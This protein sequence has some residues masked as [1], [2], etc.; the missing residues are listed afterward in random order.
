MKKT[1]TLGIAAL[2]LVGCQATQRQNAT[3][4]EME[5]NSTTKG[6]IIGATSGAV[7]GMITGDSS[8]ERRKRALI[9]AAAGG[10]VGAGVGNYFDKQEAALR[11]ELVNSGVQVK[12]VG[13]DQ[14]VLVMEN[15]IGFE[16]NSYALDPT[17]YNSLN[18]VARILVEYPDTVLLIEGH[19]DSTGSASYNQQLSQQRADS[20]RAY[21]GAQKVASTRLNTQGMGETSPVC[22]NSTEQGRR[23]N[24]R[25]EINIFPVN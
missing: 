15:G 2:M 12:R 23:C 4:G 1:M 24:R 9:G 10:A 11:Q 13:E 3:T 8:K 18:G 21:L 22:D 16:T 7:I 5:T 6:A 17:I 19:T 20:V 14:L 25:V